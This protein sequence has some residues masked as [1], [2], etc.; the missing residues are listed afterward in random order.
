MKKIAIIFF[1]LLATNYCWSNITL[2]K[3]FGNNMVLQREKLIPVWGWADPAEKV[4][5]QFNKQI[6]T[7]TAGSDGR[8]M[9]KLSAEKAGGPY[10]FLATGKNKISFSNVLVGEVWICSG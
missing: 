2:P 4:T 7:I 1:I 6:I 3:I 10:T 9:V 5:I 8:W